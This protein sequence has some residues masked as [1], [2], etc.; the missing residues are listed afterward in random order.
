VSGASG[1]VR[2]VLDRSRCI[3]SGS[4]TRVAPAVFRIDDGHLTVLD[5]E[6]PAT[7]RGDVEAAAAICPTAAIG[8]EG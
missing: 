3:A 2:V 5:H 4:C 1:H 7:S 6:P 8:V